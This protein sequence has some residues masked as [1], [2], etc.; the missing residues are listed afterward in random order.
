M[1]LAGRL[2]DSL[3]GRYEIGR[4]VGRGGMAV[5]YWARDL[6]NG[7]E[8]AIKAL[9]PEFTA[10]LAEERFLREIRIES[11]LQHPRI[12][13]ILDAGKAENQ[14]YYV[15][16]YIA[17]QTLREKLANERQLPVPDAVRIAGEIAEALGCAHEH[18][19][20]HRDIKPANIL[21]QD[22]HA[23]VADFGVA[24]AINEAGGDRL[25][26]S[27]LVIG[28]PEYMSP[29]QCSAHGSVDT[30]TDLYSLACVVYEMLAGEPPFTGSNSQQVTARHMHEAPRSLRLIRPA[31][32]Q[33]VESAVLTALAKVPADRFKSTEA[34]ARALRGDTH[35]LPL[36]L[37]LLRARKKLVVAALAAA[38]LAVWAVTG[39]TADV[40]D[41]NKVVVF[42]LVDRKPAATDA[43]AGD[44]AS[45][46]I[47][48]AL[49]RTEPLRWI[50]GW[51]WLDSAQRANATLV[52]ARQSK[53]I[54]RQRHARYY[55]EGSIVRRADSNTVILRLSDAAA[56]SLVAQASASA[57][58]NEAAISALGLRAVVQLL[59][60]LLDPKRQPDFRPLTDRR[61]AAVAS[62][63]Q[64]ERAYRQSHFS[65][66]L[67]FYKRAVGTDSELAMAALKGAQ[68]ASWTHRNTEARQLVTLALAREDLLPP[69]YA[70][71]GH[72]L[73][74]L[75]TGRAESAIAHFR[76][77]VEL[78]STW[79]EAWTALG[80]AAYH[81]A[82]QGVPWDSLAESAFAEAR[83]ADP[84]FVPPIFHLAEFALANNRVA[85]AKMLLA[86]YRRSQPDSTWVVQL[87]LMLECVRDGPAKVD[88]LSLARIYPLEVALA[89][90]TLAVVARRYA[91]AERGFRAVLHAGAVPVQA[92]WMAVFGLQNLLLAQ[93]KPEA[94]RKVVDSAVAAGLRSAMTLYIVDALAGAGTE[95]QAAE[96]MKPVAGR[97]EGMPSYRL[98][99][100][101]AWEGHLKNAANVAS[102][103]H[104]LSANTAQT[105]DPADSL[106]LSLAAASRALLGVDTANALRR[107]RD[108][109]TYGEPGEMAWGL[110]QPIAME[111]IALARLLLA[112]GA[113]LEAVQVAATFDHPQAAINLVFLPA[114]LVVRIRAARALGDTRLEARA[115][116]GL[117]ML[118]RE[119]LLRRIPQ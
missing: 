119:D 98:W 27:G 105:H 66:A 100:H 11:E 101:L 88:W 58:P 89:S 90:K 22:G 72:G 76:R 23:I 63:L 67:S 4:E 75:L 17:G 32:P 8:V 15:M 25:T 57:A 114:S 60:R 83:R 12:L 59:S 31:V 92:R 111:R 118:G 108:I 70:Q 44:E 86:E 14:L 112:Q 85:R 93:G 47:G 110:W 24:R 61:P 41:P 26:S 9:R 62:W 73:N 69:K 6:A 64:G 115:R 35:A 1:N 54:A 95:A 65:E 94:A 34:F 117:D 19:I 33:Q 107:L 20:I 109:H 43:G 81:L 48:S 80:E 30:R 21:L 56:D 36:R 2:A 102:I 78:D 84:E 42:P 104:A 18:G 16:P 116:Q 99:Y 45:L 97:Y 46:L 106:L 5:V 68:A 29:E 87:Q 55:V 53:N 52:S 113:N 39:T 103:E 38:A 96:A 37:R 51:T 50:D 3:R 77:A 79:C 49:E 10:S 71:L 7:Q 74:A 13:P 82:S 40:L 91:C 28:T